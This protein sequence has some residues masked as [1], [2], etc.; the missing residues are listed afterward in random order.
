MIVIIIKI[1]LGYCECLTRVRTPP[2][3]ALVFG[4]PYN[5][6]IILLKPLL[7]GTKYTAVDNAIRIM[8]QLSYG[9]VGGLAT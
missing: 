2:L 3:G 4:D 9:G 5:G 6:E 8:N 7:A 1:S